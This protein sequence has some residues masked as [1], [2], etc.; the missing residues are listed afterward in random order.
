MSDKEYK[1]LPRKLTIQI[2]YDANIPEESSGIT[3]I[4]SL[5]LDRFNVGQ[6]GFVDD[7]LSGPHKVDGVT[8]F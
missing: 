7:A 4:L 3:E 5:Y 8:H 2:Y 6:N 1:S